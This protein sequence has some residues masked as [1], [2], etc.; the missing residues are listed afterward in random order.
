MLDSLRRGAQGFVAKV[1]FGVLVLS[2]VVWGVADVFRGYGEGAIARVGKTEISTVEFQQS[3]QTQMDNLRR[4]F[5][6]RITPEQAR[7]LK[8]DQQIL[9][10]LIGAAA[11][12]NHTRELRLGLSEDA[13][14]EK[15]KRDQR[16]AGVDGK[17]NKSAFDGFLRQNGL[18]ERKYIELVRRDEVRDQLTVATMEA[19]QVPGAALDLLHRFREESR[20]IVHFTI[21]P[22]KVVMPDEPDDAKLA[23]TFEQN[24]RQF[25][26]PER[27]RLVALLL[28]PDEVKKGIA[29]SD[30]EIKAEYEQ[31]TE[32]FN[33]PEKRR[34]HQ[35]SF[36]D[37]AAAEAG[38]KAITDGKSFADV[39]SSAGVKDTDVDLGL[40]TKRSLIDQIIADAAFA[41]PKDKVSEVVEGRFAT[42]LLRVTE[43][44]P[45]KQRSLA[46]VSAEIRDRLATE[47]AGTEIQKLHDA[48]DDHRS[49]GKTL[50]QIA[51]TMKLKLVE[52]ASTD[53][54]GRAPDGK[55]TFEGPDG[56]RILA[57]AFVAKV[58]VEADAVEISDGGYAW[59]DVISITPE[60]QK[61]LDEV[62]ADVKAL[63]LDIETRKA[64]A[65]AGQ[66]FAERL[67]LGEAAE[68]VA[69]DAGGKVA[70]T[71]PLLRA[72]KPTGLTEQAVAQAFALPRGA[73]SSTDTVDGKS[74]IVFKVVD[75]I[76][77][78]VPTPEQRDRLKGELQRQMQSDVMAE[79]LAHLQQRFGVAVNNAAYQRAI[80]ADRGQQ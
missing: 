15:I 48:I 7:A 10:Q 17:F 51:E 62:R 54:Q 5:G 52:I 71:E 80:G 46:E 25:V 37:K 19:V 55:P 43:I 75:I 22:T 76:A 67:T 36:A 30:D 28:S 57:A 1:L 78:A 23:T 3:Y 20:T 11:I 33:L 14:A 60:T 47:R 49:S 72:A 56:E 35:L 24:K 65:A 34:V 13:I 70:A 64:L 12:D 16:F 4:R 69:A 50:Q 74:R 58:G 39:A 63:W 32:R 68:K 29:V 2:F 31:N 26:T 44:E 6:G 66:K 21:D 9:Q 59:I 53:A 18:S 77:A 40:V 61:G 27:R 42:V 8:F 79:Y 73:A 38:L 41:L 45:G